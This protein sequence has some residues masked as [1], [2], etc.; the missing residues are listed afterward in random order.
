MYP[1]VERFQLP[2]VRQKTVTEPESTDTSVW[3]KH[4]QAEEIDDGGNPW[5]A[6]AIQLV[7]Q[8][9]SID[10]CRSPYFE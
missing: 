7:N 5:L 1:I 8:S 3:I 2:R 10:H 9:V 6:R 4:F